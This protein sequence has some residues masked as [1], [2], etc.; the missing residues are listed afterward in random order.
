MTTLPANDG[1]ATT[2]D[3]ILARAALSYL[4]PLATA[5]SQSTELVRVSPIYDAP[6]LDGNGRP[7]S[8]VLNASN[9]IYQKW[10]NL[11]VYI[12][13]ID[14]TAVR[15][16][17]TNT[18][19]LS[20][21]RLGNSET[22]SFVFPGISVF[23]TFG[24]GELSWLT[25]H[26]SVRVCRID[27]EHNIHTIWIGTVNAI[28]PTEDSLGI[29]VTANGPLYDS[30][31]RVT[32]PPVRSSQAD[33]IQ[34]LGLDIAKAINTTRGKYSAVEPIITGA[35]AQIEPSW[36]KGLDYIKNLLSMAVTDAGD[37]YT[38][39]I[40]NDRKTSIVK[41]S[42][43]PN[44]KTVTLVSG[45]DGLDDTLSTDPLTGIT[46]IYGQGVTSKGAAWQ[47]TMYPAATSS[48]PRY[49][50][51]D[52][53]TTI[54]EGATD[55][56]TASGNGITILQNRLNEL[57]ILTAVTG[58]YSKATTTS[59]SRFQKSK[60][61]PVTGVLNLTTWN[62]LFGKRN[63]AK[64]AWIA[65]LATLPA[66]EPRLYDANGADLGPNPAFDP[67]LRR[68]EEFIDFGNGVS[69][70]QGKRQAEAILA[71]DGA[72]HTEGDLKLT[73]C[74]QEVARFDVMPG[75][76][77]LLKAHHGADLVLRVHRVEWQ[78]SD[79]PTVS[80]SVSTRDIDVTDLDA[81]MNRFRTSALKKTKVDQRPNSIGAG[82][83]SNTAL[84]GAGSGENFM[85]TGQHD[86]DTMYWN[87]GQWVAG[88]SNRLGFVTNVDTPISD[89]TWISQGAI[90]YF[91]VAQ[92]GRISSLG[93]Y[94]TGDLS[95]GAHLAVYE[96]NG[97]NQPGNK[98][99][100]TN[101]GWQ[102]AG[103]YTGD[104]S[105][106]MLVTPSHWIAV[107]WAPPTAEHGFAGKLIGQLPAVPRGT[108]I[109][110]LTV[111]LTEGIVAHEN[112]NWSTNALPDTAA[113]IAFG[114]NIVPII[115]AL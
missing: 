63:V 96:D 21:Q 23:E 53:D 49:P 44:L 55:D 32:P 22:A 2:T 51:D 69:L 3:H 59:V 88:E 6:A 84:T 72:P 60:D 13:D 100:E 79:V 41:M 76:S 81:A 5:L 103:F 78:L 34:D 35:L 101:I 33:V 29:R 92:A 1:V 91:R 11:V 110:D 14:V 62:R 65:P 30:S 94:Y 107:G 17:A 82:L 66:V 58:K 67:N 54:G 37:A 71:R 47:N 18:E 102:G 113:P 42:Q 57:G 89:G 36:D 19:S 109:T 90:Q 75:D 25:D 45:Q 114:A 38:V 46:T 64:D 48:A 87:N 9:V 86:G 40:D 28:V 10:G 73:V 8:G 52:P 68:L 43:L 74:P 15:N 111:K 39:W 85:P 70:E 112:W 50:L 20:W 12:N 104:L 24:T 97:A 27:P 56:L 16:V 61:L 4:G 77:V 83:G 95:G 31:Y 115:W 80:L 106:I 7:V 93:L 99:A 105:A 26:S 108:P 98:V